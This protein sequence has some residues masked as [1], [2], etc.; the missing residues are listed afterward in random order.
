MENRI[1]NQNFRRRLKKRLDKLSVLYSKDESK[2]LE[3]FM[4]L[5]SEFLVEI[6]RCR[7]RVEYYRDTRL[8]DVVEYASEVL[9]Y[10]ES[11]FKKYYKKD[12]VKKVKEVSAVKK[13]QFTLHN[14]EDVV[15]FE[16]FLDR[17]LKLL[18]LSPSLFID[19]L[20]KCPVE[21]WDKID[22]LR[23]TSYKEDRDSPEYTRCLR[24]CKKISITYFKLSKPGSRFSDE[25]NE[26]DEDDY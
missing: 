3:S 13:K 1:E 17:M 18:E 24:K 26:E 23:E 2:F 14:S 12:K 6:T 7:I 21:L 8:A 20:P 10:Y 15:R 11:V 16:G 19:T 22:D 5:E 4:G 25:Y 9:Y